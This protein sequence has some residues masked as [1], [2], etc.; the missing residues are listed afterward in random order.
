[1]AIPY[2]QEELELRDTVRAFF[3]SA[4]PR[5]TFFQSPI[6]TERNQALWLEFQKMGFLEAFD[7]SAG[8]GW[9]ESEFA[10]IAHEVG[11]TLLPEPILDSIFLHGF[12]SRVKGTESI[13]GGAAKHVF[14]IPGNLQVEDASNVQVTGLN[15]YLPDGELLILNFDL[16]QLEF[17][18]RD[19]YEI[20]AF[21]QGIELLRPVVDLKFPVG[22]RQVVKPSTESWSKIKAL[23]YLLVASQLAGIAECVFEMTHEY[24]QVRKQFGSPIGSF[25]VV[26]HQLADM[27]LAVQA[28]NASCRFAAVAANQAEEQFCFSA[29]SAMTF[30]IKNVVPLVERAV[31][32]H[33]GIGFTW[34]HPL[35]FY[36]RRAQSLALSSDVHLGSMISTAL[37]IR[38]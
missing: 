5:S 18:A 33:G 25:Q 29:L 28:L 26:Q 36:L 24:A 32:I 22:A 13:G 34:E 12:V 23:Y 14:L 27:Y 19:A 31:Q 9:G 37:E 21:N 15:T 8:N 4:Y 16:C 7:S 30:G 38:R 2:S 35:H 3:E 6:R 1:M 10:V 17:I 20:L 11:R